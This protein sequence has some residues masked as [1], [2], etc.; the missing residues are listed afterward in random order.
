MTI[1]NAILLLGLVSGAAMAQGFKCEDIKEAKVRKACIAERSKP[2]VAAEPAKAPVKEESAM[3][4]FVKEAKKELT[5]ALLDPTS[6]LF[7]ELKYVE[8]AQ[9][10]T[11][12]LCGK[13]NAK[14]SYGGYTGP[15]DF[16]AAQVPESPGGIGLWQTGMREESGRD[17]AAMEARLEVM[18]LRQLACW[19]D[20]TKSTRLAEE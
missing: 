20:G 1:R 4:K 19:G 17:L 5:S 14:N 6:P 7:S 8:N 15:K 2:A 12:A 13:V 3:D 9:A 16:V 11:K 18:K 10:G